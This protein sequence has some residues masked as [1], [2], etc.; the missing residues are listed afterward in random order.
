M[1][2]LITR[3][4]AYYGVDLVHLTVSFESQLRSIIVDWNPESA[5]LQNSINEKEIILPVLSSKV[6]QPSNFGIRLCWRQPTLIIVS[7][8]AIEGFHFVF[9]S[10]RNLLPPIATVQWPESRN[11]ISSPGFV[12]TTACATMSVFGKPSVTSDV[13]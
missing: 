1:V 3:A 8:M 2:I 6:E 4:A 13:A 9:S 11:R 5:Y 7:F 10:I 12:R